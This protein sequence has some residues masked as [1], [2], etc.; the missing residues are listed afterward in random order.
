MRVNTGWRK[1]QFRAAAAMAA[2]CFAVPALPA[3][4]GWTP[5][6]TIEFVVGSSPGSGTDATA[7]FIQRLLETKEM[8][9]VP[10]V[11]A[12]K[13]GGGSAI[14]FA[15]LSQRA[16]NPYY[17]VLGS[18]N[19]VTNHLTGKSKLGIDDFTPLALLFNEYVSFN[20]KADSKIK[21][22]RDLIE[23]VRRDPKSVSFG[24][25]SSVAGANHIALA[26]VMSKAGVDIHKLKIVVFSS[27]GKSATAL[28]GGHVD[29]QVVS[30]SRAAKQL[31][32]GRT[33]MLAIASPQR[34]QRE[35]ATVPTWKEVGIPA[36]ASNWRNVIG[37][38]DL[39]KEEVAYWDG[40]L[41]R[42][43]KTDD[44]EKFLDRS[45]SDNAY[46]NSAQTRKYLHEQSEEIRAIL[47]D[48]G[49]AK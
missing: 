13:P 22:A 29:V 18:Y 16:G 30:A 15:Y 8:L 4:A 38:K 9:P 26:L 36:I 40:L 42:M 31:K 48:L 32:A 28:L 6:K 25:S 37:A 43:V 39:S 17:A 1:W 2:V 23:R 21:D 45:F 41:S 14:A 46:L 34:L 35:L 47:V 5:E 10:M 27:G 49:L 12:N 11:V 24:I 7:R 20:V 33:R 3:A 19:L 44:W